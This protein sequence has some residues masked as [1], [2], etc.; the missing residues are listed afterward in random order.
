MRL[1]NGNVEMKEM[2]NM[3]KLANIK[4]I[5]DLVEIEKDRGKDLEECKDNGDI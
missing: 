3:T 1:D 5:E 4:D 2:A